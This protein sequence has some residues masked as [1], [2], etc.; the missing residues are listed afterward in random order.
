MKNVCLRAYVGLSSTIRSRSWI[1]F[2]SISTTSRFLSWFILFVLYCFHNTIKQICSYIEYVL[3]FAIFFSFFQKSGRIYAIGKVHVFIPK[4]VIET[5]REWN[6]N[7][8]QKDDKEYDKHLVEA[9]L[10]VCVENKDLLTKNINKNTKL[11][12][13]GK[14]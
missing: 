7:P 1:I 11:F 10:L 13:R 3:V 9:L 2:Y 5:L 8:E 12:I 4:N 6:V 14:F